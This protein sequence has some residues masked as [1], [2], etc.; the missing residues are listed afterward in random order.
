MPFAFSS[1]LVSRK[2]TRVSQLQPCISRH[3]PKHVH[4]TFDPTTIFRQ[5]TK[6]LQR[7]RSKPNQSTFKAAIDSGASD[8]F[9]PPVLP[10]TNINP[11]LTVPLSVLPMMKPSKRLQLMSSHSQNSPAQP[12]PAKSLTRSAFPLFQLES[13]VIT[14]CVSCSMPLRYGSITSAPNK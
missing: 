13:Y 6:R 14:V 5:T 1:Q 10:P 9:S 3:F 8:H 4:I 11:S 12:A 7:R 2:S